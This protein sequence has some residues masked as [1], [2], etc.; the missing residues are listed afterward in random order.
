MGV[1]VIVQGVPYSTVRAV[2]RL[3]AEVGDMVL[4]A[5]ELARS[6]HV[7]ATVMLAN[8]VRRMV[9][10]PSTPSDYRVEQNQK[11]DLRRIKREYGQDTEG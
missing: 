11:R 2:K 3:V 9:V 10:F 1:V 4:V 6:G 7:K 5:L 8:G